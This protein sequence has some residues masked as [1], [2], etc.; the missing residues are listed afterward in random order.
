MLNA[1]SSG[2][3]LT[4][5]TSVASGGRSSKRRGAAARPQPASATPA[6]TSSANRSGILRRRP[7]PNGLAAAWGQDEMETGP[8]VD[9]ALRNGDRQRGRER[10]EEHTS[11]LQSR[12][13]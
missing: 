5:V 10:S 8:G 1:V 9:G 11:E 13:Q 12:L 7:N 4:N 3:R 2:S 6:A